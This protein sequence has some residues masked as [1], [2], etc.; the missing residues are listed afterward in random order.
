MLVVFVS[1]L[2][3]LIVPSPELYQ[4][5]LLEQFVY[6]FVLTFFLIVVANSAKDT[7]GRCGARADARPRRP[8]ALRPRPARRTDSVHLARAASSGHRGASIRAHYLIKLSMERKAREIARIQRE[9]DKL[10][11][12]ILPESIAGRCALRLLACRRPWEGR[13][14]GEASQ[15]PTRGGG[16]FHGRSDPIID[17]EFGPDKVRGPATAPWAACW[18][19]APRPWPTR[20]PKWRSCSAPSTTFPVRPTTPPERVR[21]RTTT[22]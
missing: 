22:L 19:C 14:R 9:S 8:R 13:A 11:R 6:Y 10:F 2:L 12:N 21:A 20:I 3:G 4:P 15:G 18:T 7:I 16:A 1:L 5:V 17:H